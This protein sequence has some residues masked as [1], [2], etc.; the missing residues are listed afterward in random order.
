MVKG[1]P[2]IRSF[3]QSKKESPSKASESANNVVTS[4]GRPPLSSST[5]A[6]SNVSNFQS[7]LDGRYSQLKRKGR[8]AENDLFEHLNSADESHVGCSSTNASSPERFS[9]SHD[10]PVRNKSRISQF[11]PC[12]RL[13]L[14]ST[15][16]KNVQGPHTTGVYEYLSRT[17]SIQSSL[18]SSSDEEG[19]TTEDSAPSSRY[20]SDAENVC[21]SR[22]LSA[23]QQEGL[24][25]MSLGPKIESAAST[26]KKTPTKPSRSG[27]NGAPC[28]SPSS[29]RA[30]GQRSLVPLPPSLKECASQAQAYFDLEEKV[31]FWDDHNVQVVVRTRPISTKEATK[32]DV[33]RCLRQ[34]SAHA[35]TWLGQPETRFTF[36]HVAGENISQEKLF[37][38]VGLPI[39]ENCMAGYN[40][41]MFAYGQTGSGKTHTML[42]DVTDLGHKPSDNRGM[43]PRIFEYLFSKIRKEEQH[44]QL[45]QLEYVCRCSF[46]EIYN[47][48][49]TDLL[50]P[51]STN[52]HMREDSKKGVYVENLTEIVVR[53]VQDVVVLLLKGAANRKVAS[54]IMNRES[55]R[56]HS[57]F[58]CTIESKWVTNSMS[59]MR[60]G[61]LNLVD[62]AGSERQKSSGTERD[63]LK[64]AASINKS[65]STLG[66][67][68]MI[69]VDIAN[70][71]Q[72]HVPYRDSKLTF[73]L[74]DSLGGNSKTAIIATISPS[75]CCTMETLSTLKFAQRAKFIQ[76]NAVV[77]EDASGELLALKRE[78]QQ[79]KEEVSRL[80]CLSITSMRRECGRESTEFF[81]MSM[82]GKDLFDGAEKEVENERVDLK[83][84]Q[85]LE[86][87]KALKA[88]LIGALRRGQAAEIV[89]KQLSTNIDKAHI[90]IEDCETESRASSK[91][92]Q[93][94]T[95]A[96]KLQ[97]AEGLGHK[98]QATEL[99]SGDPLQLQSY[100]TF[101]DVGEEEMTATEIRCLRDQVLSLHDEKLAMEQDMLSTA[102]AKDNGNRKE[103]ETCRND[104]TK[105]LEASSQ[106]QK[107]VDELQGLV[108]QLTEQCAEKDE[109]L[110]KVKESAE[111]H[112]RLMKSKEEEIKDLQSAW[113]AATAKLY[114]NLLEGEQALVEAGQE[115]SEIMK[116]ESPRWSLEPDKSV[117]VVDTEHDYFRGR[118]SCNMDEIFEEKRH[119]RMT[120]SFGLSP[121]VSLISTEEKLKLEA[122]VARL[123]HELEEHKQQVTEE[124]GIHEEFQRVTKENLGLKEEIEAM[125]LVQEELR[126]N[127]STIHVKFDTISQKVEESNLRAKEVEN[128]YVEELKLKAGE[129]KSGELR[130]YELEGSLA[131]KCKALAT[132]DSAFNSISATCDTLKKESD[133]ARGYIAHLQ[134]EAASSTA[135]LQ[136]LQDELELKS[137]EVELLSFMMQSTCSTLNT[138]SGHFQSLSERLSWELERKQHQLIS[139]TTSHQQN[140]EL[141]YESKFKEDQLQAELLDLKK[142][143]SKSECHIARAAQTISQLDETVE[144]LQSEL[145]RKEELL[146]GLEFD[147]RLLQEH[148][149]EETDFKQEIIE[150]NSR[151]RELE[152]EVQRKCE[153]LKELSSAET[154]MKEQLALKAAAVKR[155]EEEFENL[156][157]PV[158][159][160]IIES[161][162]LKSKVMQLQT[163]V[164]AKEEELANKAHAL[165]SLDKELML[166][167]VISTRMTMECSHKSEALEALQSVMQRV[168]AENDGLKA[169]CSVLM[170]EVNALQGKITQQSAEMQVLHGEL[171]V[172]IMMEYCLQEMNSDISLSSGS[173]ATNNQRM[174]DLEAK[175]ESVVNER[176]SLKAEVGHKEAT[177]GLLQSELIKVK[178]VADHFSH[179][180][181]AFQALIV[182]LQGEKASF[183]AELSCKTTLIMS[184]EAE[185]AK[186]DV[187]STGKLNAFEGF[188]ELRTVKD[189]RNKALEKVQELGNELRA[190]Q[191]LVASYEASALETRK[192][193]EAII[194]RANEKDEESRA[195]RAS[196]IL[197]TDKNSALE[198]Q[199]RSDFETELQG[200]K[201]RM[202]ILQAV[203]STGSRNHR[204]FQTATPASPDLKRMLE[205]K[206]AEVAQSCK[207]IAALQS[208]NATQEK[209]LEELGSELAQ[210]HQELKTMSTQWEDK[211]GQL[212]KL[213]LLNKEA[214]TL[215]QDVMQDLHNVKLDIGNYAALVSQQQLELIA[216]R[217]QHADEVREKDEELSNLRA[218]LNQERQNWMQEMNHKQAEIVVGRALSE[219]MK[220]KN[221][222]L[223][224]DYKKLKVDFSKKKKKLKLLEQEMTKLATDAQKHSTDLESAADFDEV[225][226]FQALLAQAKET[227][228]FSRAEDSDADFDELQQFQALLAQAN[229]HEFG[230]S[231]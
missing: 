5:S 70:G 175:I 187:V 69:L 76:N 160:A 71:K 152:G 59:N 13:P 131:E 38:V 151:I 16:S 178:K 230:R 8:F 214:E 111:K 149:A 82:R 31:S 199:A 86:E 44:K 68:I 58:T 101:F 85:L 1:T 132:L 56:S 193:S 100:Q 148:A 63:R 138:Q 87:I 211:E 11:S 77:N 41:C 200:M 37:E 209:K 35:I 67:V 23:R 106:L 72:R 221:K 220:L 32:Q 228:R 165:S 156:R 166:T 202:S 108:K 115:L 117:K 146:H 136:K 66:L 172:S 130:I 205:E 159:L 206:E 94:T 75:S 203:H 219:K 143:V 50:E 83:P 231:Q 190:V 185:L 3:F 92:G 229:D 227:K 176:D 144:H 147:I 127:L 14:S 47:E 93:H 128:A 49:I 46:L 73:L 34:E 213:T 74:Q 97:T 119:P 9:I 197:L 104:L 62:L 45:E 30:G 42:G 25:R 137:F 55:S 207:R 140:Q 212:S 133:E 217:S 135:Q 28:A 79:L 65:L 226:Q 24:R 96:D 61:R 141:L 6:R 184:L 168:S 95:M 33:A 51:S 204:G 114:Q 145:Q 53:S 29:V 122:T 27:R 222:T 201:S 40:S 103:L 191:A 183:E 90:S 64:E 123:K 19:T 110:N 12:T 180:A 189:E 18:A 134:D 171:L 208:E 54:T 155:M 10:N 195:L 15:T 186:V 170:D 182:E 124:K 194:I 60:F 109:E 126:M 36:D 88:G 116:E 181:S 2:N 98:A 157:T 196:V 20:A 215:T 78:I 163:D 57:V 120:R 48:Q 158:G 125:A 102:I 121:R 188:G 179:E 80:R 81:R 142:E 113:D 21:P 169:Q 198:S 91:S 224:A 167:R 89:I 150:A 216:E 153:E 192:F 17:P 118:G 218:Q 7:R 99:E 225:Q 112:L 52:L 39:V 4:P 139:L 174:N 162:A 105:C 107:Q 22:Q 210:A 129:I 173:F 164:S 177:I 43:T 26:P 161:Q 84:S 154:F 223:I